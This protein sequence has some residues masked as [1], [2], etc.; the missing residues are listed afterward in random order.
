M[1]LLPFACQAT[2]VADTNILGLLVTDLQDDNR[3]LK[4]TSLI[5]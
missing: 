3:Y 4:V 1:E 5:S 2:E